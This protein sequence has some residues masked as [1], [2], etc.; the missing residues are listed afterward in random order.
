MNLLN[1][2]NMANYYDNDS[3]AGSNR[4]TVKNEAYVNVDALDDDY[5]DEDGRRNAGNVNK[6][7][8]R[9]VS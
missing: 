6:N 4:N 2:A 8:V 9:P 7:Y 1:Q 5:G 3:E